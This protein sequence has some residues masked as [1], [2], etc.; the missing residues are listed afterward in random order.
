MADKVFADGI[1]FKKPSP[2]APEWV[3]GGISIKVDEFIEW[4]QKNRYGGEWVNIDVKEGKSKKV[5]CELSTYDPKN[6]TPKP[7]SHVEQ[8]EESQQKLNTMDSTIEYPDE[9]IDPKD[10]PF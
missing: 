8:E 4:L 10:I 5:Y 3:V 2:K 1:I 6:A 9:D 7:K